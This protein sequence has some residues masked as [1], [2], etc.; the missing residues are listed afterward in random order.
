MNTLQQNK[1][2]T[3]YN[4]YNTIIKPLMAE[5]EA[6]E[7][8]MP[9]PIFNEIRAFNDHIARCYLEGTHSERINNEL[10]KAERHITRITLDCFKCLNISL[11]KQ[12][13]K[14]EKQTRNIDLTVLNNGCF[15]PRYCELKRLAVNHIQNAKKQEGLNL[16]SSLNE[17]QIAYNTYREVEELII[18]HAESVKWARVRFTSKRILSIL[19]WILSVVI[20]G[21][22]SL[23]ISCDML[24]QWFE[25]LI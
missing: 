1:I 20:S 13:E 3:L 19:L 8:R 16:D 23:L 7:E 11:Y 21:L 4:Q 10:L 15:Y 25:Y 12:I 6:R 24:S 22:L 18:N 14:F 17:F 5:I 2:T 9:L